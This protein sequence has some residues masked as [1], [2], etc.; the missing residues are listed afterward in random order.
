MGQLTLAVTCGVS[1]FWLRDL[2]LLF[3]DLWTSWALSGTDGPM[4]WP[5]GPQPIRSC[6]CSRK[7]TSPCWSRAGPKVHTLPPTCWEFYPG[8]SCSETS[9]RGSLGSG[10]TAWGPSAFFSAYHLPKV[11]VELT[12]FRSSFAGVFSQLDSEVLQPE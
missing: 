7:V 6:S 4:E 8:N 2:F 12:E 11:S 3:A 10:D 9:G 1:H 5:L